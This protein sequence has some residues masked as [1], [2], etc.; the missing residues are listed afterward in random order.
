MFEH[1]NRSLLQGLTILI[2]YHVWIALTKMELVSPGKC[3]VELNLT[4]IRT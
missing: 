3:T 2:A 4:T 1:D